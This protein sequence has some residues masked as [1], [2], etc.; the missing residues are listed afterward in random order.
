MV[1]GCGSTCLFNPFKHLG[2]GGRRISN[3][4]LVWGC[5]SSKPGLYREILPKRKQ[6]KTKAEIKKIIIEERKLSRERLAFEL[7]MQTT[8]RTQMHCVELQKI[9]SLSEEWVMVRTLGG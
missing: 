1:V 2:G 8:L 6:N 7:S 4:R 3:S 9:H 5:I